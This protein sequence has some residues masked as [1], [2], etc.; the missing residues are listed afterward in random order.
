MKR[1]LGLAAALVLFTAPALAGRQAPS[2]NPADV[3]IPVT[4]VYHG[5]SAAKAPPLSKDDVVVH[6]N[7]NVRPV[8]DWRPLTGSSS[9]IDLAVLVD[10]SL[11]ATV[12]L[13]WRDVAGFIRLLP[14]GSH[15]AIAYGAHGAATMVQPFTTDR[16]RAIK[17]LRIPLGRVSGGGSIYLSLSE[18]VR[19][20]PADGRPRMVLLVSDGVDL[21]YGVL[22]S[23][24]SLNPNLQ[25]AIDRS[26]RNGVVVNAIYAGGASASSHNLFLINNGQGCLARL[27]LETGGRAYT[28]G[29]ESPISFSPFLRQM[30]E[31]IG[32]MY[33]LTFRAALPAKA[34]FAR[35]RLSAEPP[36]VELL[37]PSRVYLPAA[38]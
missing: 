11:S 5:A 20:W 6:Q 32:R 7:G 22:E 27:A 13:Q 18:L 29:L 23:E 36:G 30:A 25:Q 4:V 15:V 33:R 3:A 1:L 26:Q 34:G 17:S 9:G 8:L 28:Q 19:D 2:S 14:K 37:G 31:T 21:Y 38:P 12:S 10:D 24:P 16:E 35:I